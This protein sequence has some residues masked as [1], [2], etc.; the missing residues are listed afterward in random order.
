QVVDGDDVAV[1]QPARGARLPQEAGACVL[2]TADGAA[3]DLEGD[4][5][6]DDGVVRL[7]HGAH[8]TFPDELVQLELPDAALLIG[9]RHTAPLGRT[10]QFALCRP[11]G[12]RV[13][14]AFSARPTRKCAATW[15]ASRRP[16]RRRVV[17]GRAR[18]S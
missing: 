1:L 11:T 8:R 10:D 15:S 3:Q 12:E 9:A 14:R 16:R 7:P 18:R 4:V 5:A 6:T 2:R 17:A 13:G